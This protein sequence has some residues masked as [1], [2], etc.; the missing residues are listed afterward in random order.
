MGKLKLR[1]K[2]RLM[3]KQKLKPRQKQESWLHQRPLQH[4]EA[5]KKERTRV[6][7]SS[8]P[9]KTQ[10]LQSTLT[11]RERWTHS[12]Y[13]NSWKTPPPRKSF[14]PTRLPF[15][16]VVTKP[17]CGTSPSISLSPMPAQTSS[18]SKFTKT[19]LL[20]K[21]SSARV[22]SSLVSSVQKSQKSSK[23]A[24]VLATKRLSNYTLKE[25]LREFLQSFL[26]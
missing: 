4:L 24:T 18:L 21:T 16:R 25:C 26:K 14:G 9:A 17:P 22:L 1:Q 3:S 2:L 19:T 11:S 7:F 12:S 6:A 20:A 5:A 15:T 10:R 8:S 13:L 23:E